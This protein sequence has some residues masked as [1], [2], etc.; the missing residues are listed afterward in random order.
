MVELN[1]NLPPDILAKIGRFL[2]HPLADIIRA[3]K[4]ATMLTAKR[5][6]EDLR[7]PYLANG[8]TTDYSNDYMSIHNMDPCDDDTYAQ[9]Y[10]W[11]IA[12]EKWHVQLVSELDDEDEYA[13]VN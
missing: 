13:R 7:Y 6:L 9:C 5:L 2:S 10:F 11:V 12:L 3:D 1:I 8:D 4:R